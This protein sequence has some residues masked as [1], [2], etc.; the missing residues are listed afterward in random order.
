MPGF[1]LYERRDHLI[2]SLKNDVIRPE[3]ASFFPKDEKGKPRF[4]HFG[5]LVTDAVLEKLPPTPIK[6]RLDNCP[7]DCKASRKRTNAK[8]V[9]EGKPEPYPLL[10]YPKKLLCAPKLVEPPPLPAKLTAAKKTP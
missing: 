4:L 9:A 5:E 6:D 3:L 7:E 8:A 2:K 1:E 10:Q